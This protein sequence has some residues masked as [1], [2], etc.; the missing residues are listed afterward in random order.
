MQINKI[1]KLINVIAITFGVAFFDGMF[2]FGLDDN[3]YLVLGLIQLITI[4]M[5]LYYIN[6]K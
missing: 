4:I 1:K 3:A 6:Q 5:L 2:G